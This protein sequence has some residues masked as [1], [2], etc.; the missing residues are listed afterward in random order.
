MRCYLE[1]YRARV[2]TW[3]GDSWDSRGVETV[4]LVTP[5][6]RVV[7]VRVDC[8]ELSNFSSLTDYWGY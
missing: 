5:T 4:G 6:R 3:S 8:T 1:D 7:I 2:G